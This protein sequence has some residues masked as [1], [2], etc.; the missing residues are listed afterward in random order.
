MLANRRRDT[1]IELA[2]RRRL[3]SWGLRYRVDYPPLSGV[4][5]RADIVFTRA[6]LAVFIDGCFW[7]QCPIHGVLPKQNA[8]YWSPK[9]SAN[10]ARDAN[11]NDMLTSAG[12]TVLRFWEHEDPDYVAAE[13]MAAVRPSNDGG[14]C[15]KFT[16]KSDA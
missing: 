6:K 3:H 13:I 11:T 12:W 2:V 10:V 4:R 8:S 9:L 7:H 5:R 16:S 15:A 1:S 14:W